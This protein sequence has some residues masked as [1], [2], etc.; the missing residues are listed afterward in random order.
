L[1]LALW[2]IRQLRYGRSLFARAKAPGGHPRVCS[3]RNP[4]ASSP[5]LEDV[6]K[7]CFS[8]SLSLSL[9]SSVQPA[10]LIT[11]RYCRFRYGRS[12]TVFSSAWHNVT[13]PVHFHAVLAHTALPSI[14]VPRNTLLLVR[15]CH[16]HGTE[17]ARCV[18]R[19][20]SSS[21]GLCVLLRF[22]WLHRVC[23]L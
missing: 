20:A 16:S 12:G 17:G 21:F 9:S 8:L 13:W 4:R 10:L 15:C 3:G 23:M 22:A 2:L 5:V 18:C 6:R 14:P 7:S 19:E 1:P 11:L